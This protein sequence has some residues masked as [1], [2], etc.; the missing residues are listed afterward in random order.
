M[1]RCFGI[2]LRPAEAHEFAEGCLQL[3]CSLDISCTHTREISGVRDLMH[4]SH[5]FTS[6]GHILPASGPA[7]YIR[8][9]LIVS[10]DG[11]GHG[12]HDMS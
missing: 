9:C 5:C 11:D 1:E 8:T 3:C 10:R 4:F 7:R 12:Q 6:Y 2:L